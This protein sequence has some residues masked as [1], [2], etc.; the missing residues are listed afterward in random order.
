MGFGCEACDPP[1]VSHYFGIIYLAEMVETVEMAET[2]L[3][4]LKN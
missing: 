3:G 1:F 2:L 4:W